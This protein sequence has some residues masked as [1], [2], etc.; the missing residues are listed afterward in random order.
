MAHLFL[1]CKDAGYLK[2]PLG[3]TFLEMLQVFDPAKLCPDCEVIRTG[4]SRHCS[5]CNK[6]VERFD[7]HCPWINS[8]VGTAN[9]GAFFT[10][11]LFMDTLLVATITVIFCNLNCATNLAVTR[12]S[13][14]L[15][16]PLLPDY[17]Y[18]PDSINAC[19]YTTATICCIFVLP[20]T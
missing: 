15:I 9:Q 2:K 19:I 14:F 8:C 11:L 6:C 20:V 1:L 7:H 18:V 10:F 17:F 16:P 4:K 3:V 5:I 12:D 13:G